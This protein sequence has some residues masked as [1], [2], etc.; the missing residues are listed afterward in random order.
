MKRSVESSGSSDMVLDGLFAP[1]AFLRGILAFHAGFRIDD[2]PLGAQ[3]HDVAGSLAK[4][5]RLAQRLC[6]PLLL[7]EM[8]PPGDNR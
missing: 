1:G 8:I 3:G 7:L 4:I 2:R 5:F 6:V